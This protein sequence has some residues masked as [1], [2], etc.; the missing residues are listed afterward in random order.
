MGGRKGERRKKG[1][2]AG[3]KEGVEG[4]SNSDPA[5]WS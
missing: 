4:V 5:T 1:E 2:K 3:G